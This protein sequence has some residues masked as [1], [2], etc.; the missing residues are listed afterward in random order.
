M[1]IVLDTVNKIRSFGRIRGKGLSNKVKDIMESVLPK[2]LINN[3]IN[4]N[5]NK[6]FNNT[7][8]NCLEIG[9]GYGESLAHKAQFY[10]NKNFVG[11]EV[12]TNGV[13]N[14]ASLLEENNIENAKIFNGD[15]RIFLEN[16]LDNSLETI[17]ILFPDPWPKKK[18]NKRRLINEEFIELMYKKLIDNG[19]VIFV[20]DIEDYIEWTKEKFNNVNKFIEKEITKPDW[21]IT[22]RYQ[23]KAIEAGRNS[24]FLEFQK[25]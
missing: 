16:L 10:K 12:Y 22:T 21:W 1:A 13:S 14:L 25:I 15:S 5:L 4:I 23:E 6:I 9:F 18:Q 7:N 3:E 8:K 17:Y 24:Y 2:Y 20:S 19:K 11:C